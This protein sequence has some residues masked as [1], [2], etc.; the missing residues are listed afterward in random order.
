MKGS[1]AGVCKTNRISVRVDE[2]HS[3]P[4]EVALLLGESIKAGQKLGWARR[5]CFRELFHE[6]VA[7]D[8]MR[9]ERSTQ[10]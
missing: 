10:K 6:M 1:D 7:N 4:T 8:L 9:V 5:V 3:R 2:R